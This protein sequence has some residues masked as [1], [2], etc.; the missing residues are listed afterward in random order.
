MRYTSETI[1]QEIV[2]PYTGKRIAGTSND[3]VQVVATI[4]YRFEGF[5]ITFSGVPARWDRVQNRQFLAR[6]VALDFN[7][8]MN[9]LATLL[10]RKQ[11]EQPEEDSQ[12]EDV[13]GQES[14]M[15]R[16]LQHASLT[17]SIHAPTFL[18]GAA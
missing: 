4:A 5:T 17:V 13:L 9:E 10:E 15:Q 3:V 8:K 12:T 11:Q 14:H 2:G 16:L 1:E 7:N 18:R 6:S